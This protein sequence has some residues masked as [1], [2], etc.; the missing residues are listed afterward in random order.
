M[1]VCTESVSQW[2][3]GI[4]PADRLWPRVVGFLGYDPTPAPKTLGERLRAARLRLGLSMKAFS[5]RL[6]C[7]ESTIAKWE[8]DASIPGRRYERMLDCLLGE[9]WR[10]GAGESVKLKL[11]LEGE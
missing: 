4:V 11:H 5:K 9:T 3:G 10:I 7:D 2:E 6:G 8:A 1:G